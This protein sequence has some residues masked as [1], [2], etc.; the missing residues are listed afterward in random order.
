MQGKGWEIIESE[1]TFE[2]NI[3]IF[4]TVKKLFDLENPTSSPLFES[5]RT[6]VKR[7]DL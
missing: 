5:F 4:K 2:E 7:K 6:I 1:R 3:D